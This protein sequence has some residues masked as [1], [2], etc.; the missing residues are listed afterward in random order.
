[1]CRAIVLFGQHIAHVPLRAADLTRDGSGTLTLAPKTSDLTTSV[2][3]ARWNINHATIKA[4]AENPCGV[5]TKC[6]R[7]RTS[8]VGKIR[9]TDACA[10]TMSANWCA[11]FSPNS[12]VIMSSVN[13]NSFI[14]HSP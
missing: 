10:A 14:F 2:L 13:C 8:L 7:Q 5:R 11:V 4:L 9:N 1:M 3:A 12:A 6:I